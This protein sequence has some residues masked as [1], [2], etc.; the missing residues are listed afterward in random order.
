MSIEKP[1]PTDESDDVD[2]PDSSDDTDGLSKRYRVKLE[3]HYRDGLT[4]LNCLRKF[5]EDEVD[6]LDAD[7]I[8]P[9]GVGGGTHHRQIASLCR[10][11]HDAKHKEDE[12]A[13]TIRWMSTGDMN[14]TEWARYRHFWDEMFPALVEAATGL[15]IQV[16]RDIDDTTPWQARHLPLGYHRLIED[17]LTDRDEIDFAPLGAHHYM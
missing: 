13:P 16:L 4:C 5:T 15:Q 6:Q 17:I 7:H 11:C 9:E 3:A 14:D 8:V 10:E 2:E 1:D 12:I